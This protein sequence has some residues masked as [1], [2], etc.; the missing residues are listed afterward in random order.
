MSVSAKND[1]GFESCRA[2]LKQLFNK[3][4]KDQQLFYWSNNA[5][6]QVQKKVEAVPA[7]LIAG[8]TTCISPE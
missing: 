6:R 3:K 2:E 8:L 5:V 7:S 1:Q 4:K